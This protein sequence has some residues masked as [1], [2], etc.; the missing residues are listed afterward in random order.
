MK[1][2]GWVKAPSSDKNKQEERKYL[3]LGQ[4]FLETLLNIKYAA[5]LSALGE[6]SQSGHSVLININFHT[7]EEQV[8]TFITR[9]KV[10]GSEHRHHMGVQSRTGAPK[11]MHNPYGTTT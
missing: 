3:G 9:V 1:R 10:Q 8:S 11:P 6:W 4:S 5:Q 2:R 7:L